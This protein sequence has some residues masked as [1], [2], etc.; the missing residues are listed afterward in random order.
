MKKLMLL[1]TFIISSLFAT[2]GW[3][4]KTLTPREVAT[5]TKN[6]DLLFLKKEFV[7]KGYKATTKDLTETIADTDAEGEFQLDVIYQDYKGKDKTQKDVSVVRIDFSRKGKI[8]ETLIYAEDEAQLYSVVQTLPKPNSKAKPTLAIKASAKSACNFNDCVNAAI[9]ASQNCP[10]CLA[11]LRLCNS[12]NTFRAKIWCYIG[13]LLTK[14]CRNCIGNVFAII[15]CL[16]N[17]LKS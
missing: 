5:R 2:N 16:K 6:A 11:N 15:K 3:S 4:Q 13:T 14:P 9:G 8:T 7:A 10:N 17:C 12:K 1:M